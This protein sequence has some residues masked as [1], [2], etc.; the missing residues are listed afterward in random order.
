MPPAQVNTADVSEKLLAPKIELKGNVVSLQN[1]VI[2]A[3]VA[4]QLMQIGMV[5][6]IFEEG[7]SIA[8][9]ND[10]ELVLR[11]GMETANLRSLQADLVF[12]NSE[13]ER[14]TSLAKRDNASKTQL[15]QAIA[16]R[17]MLD[18]D[19]VV[20]KFRIAAVKRGLD[21]SKV[22]AP[23]KGMLTKR[24][25]QKGE[26]INVGQS[27]AQLVDTTN[28]EI[29]VPIPLN[30]IQLL[31]KGDNLRVSSSRS[32][33][34]LQ[35]RDIV[36]VGDQQ[37]RSAEARLTAVGTDLI[38]GE[39]VSVFAPRAL[40]QKHITIPRDALVIRGKRTFVY[41]VVNNTA[42]QVLVNVVFADG[43]TVA[44]KGELTSTDR[45]IVRG[46][47]RLQPGS[48]VVEL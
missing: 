38:I 18:Q 24:L 2:G 25:A 39:S 34:S 15:Q 13:V 5:G 45:V 31:S 23:F 6:S 20:A 8:L 30:Y 44:V 43:D 28:I 1:S 14:F 42:E 40:A 26:F 11:M 27:I 9:V 21:K 16:N 35:V 32:T 46:A 19:I 7:Q 3:E 4:G 10:E 33:Y 41:R 47:E 48:P 37:T 22:P 12:R 17:D 29:S 36:I